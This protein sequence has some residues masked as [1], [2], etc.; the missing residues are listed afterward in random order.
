MPIKELQV[1]EEREAPCPCGGVIRYRPIFFGGRESTIRPKLC[2]A[3]LERQ[4]VDAEHA[5]EQEQAD[6][7]DRER[8]NREARR[9]ELL[10]AM[11]GNAAEHRDMTLANFDAT[12]CGRDV[13][14][15]A[16]AFFDEMR[17]AGPYD[18]VRGLLL[19][20]DTG[21]GKTHLAVAGVNELLLDPTVQPSD[22]VFDRA[23]ELIMRIQD[24]YG[25][26]RSTFEDV[27]D[28]RF[29]ARLWILDELGTEKA[30]EDAARLLTLI[31]SRRA[32][33]PTIVT[34]NDDPAKLHDARPELRRVISRFGPRYFRVVRMVGRDRRF[35]RPSAA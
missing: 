26:G 17:A 6:R 25:S 3:C 8:T 18:P 10:Q 29:N 30:S 5:V 35:D 13:V 9:L 31:F 20:G 7:L 21:N 1:A 15:K 27:M 28:R 11:T 4:R 2:P 34:T 33:R 22:I 14:L 24:T 23:D 12:D 19:W 16:Q 32:L